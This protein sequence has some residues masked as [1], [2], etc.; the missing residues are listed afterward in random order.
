M[1]VRWT[2]LL[3]IIGASIVTLIPR[4]LPLMVFSRM[5]LPEWAMRWLSYVPIA[6]MAALVGQE[7]LLEDGKPTSFYRSAEFYA[8]I[9]AIVTAIWTRSLL[10]TVIAGVLSVIALRFLSGWI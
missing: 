10:A 1:E 5:K 2:V 3:V 9:S 6:V 8:A 4:V 7:L